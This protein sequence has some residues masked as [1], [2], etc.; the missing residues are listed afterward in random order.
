MQV[1]FNKHTALAILR[2]LRTNGALA[3]THRSNIIPPDPHPR[4]SWVNS[5]LKEAIATLPFKLDLAEFSIAVPSSDA[6]IRSKNATCTTY[7]GGMPEKSF[8]DIGNG[9]AIS[10]PELL[11]AE[12]AESMHPVEHLM[13][14]HELCG[15]FARNAEDPYNGNIV[16]NLKPLTSAA[17]IARF[18][19]E[20][21][22]M[23]GIGAAR[24]TVK[25]LNDNAWSPT[26]S[27]IAAFLRLPID[28]L[29]FDLGE[30]SLNPRVDLTAPLPGAKS[31]RYPDIVI[32]ETPVGVNYDGLVHLDLASIVR[33][34]A[35]MGA[36]PEMSQAQFEVDR[37]IR[38]VRAKALDD[39][40][41]NRELAAS[42]LY[43]LPVLKEDLYTP[44]GLEMLVRQLV[45]SLERLTD[46]DMSV[47]KSI[48][49]SG[50]FSAARHRMLLSLLPGK[51]VVDA[52]T[53][54]QVKGL[55][56][57]E[58]EFGASE[59]WIEL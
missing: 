12:L 35:E 31:K 38:N 37:A 54:Q 33:A 32:A 47:Q 44:N 11:F 27:I 7:A 25:L 18:L 21:K 26:E 13:L 46:R 56:I 52:V 34:S 17:K 10:G 2:T 58:D 30:L 29:G 9:I 45:D 57:Y 3:Q 4:K 6:R 49:D 28:C 23:R 36:H 55:R 19:E 42:G 41:R 5:A 53:Y 16:Y 1:T 59:C 22:S 51:H 43:V 20:A 14:G 50:A 40:R 39:I 48:L 15:S 8:L 24:D